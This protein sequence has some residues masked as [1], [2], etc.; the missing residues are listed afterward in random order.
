MR[1]GSLRIWGLNGEQA[2]QPVASKAG[3]IDE[4]IY[5][6]G[7]MHKVSLALP[8]AIIG[9]WVTDIHKVLV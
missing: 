6:D 7:H 2:A 5:A 3:H 8:A 9:I 4:G 1:Y